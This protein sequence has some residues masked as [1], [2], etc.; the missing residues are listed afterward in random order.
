VAISPRSPRRPKISLIVPV[1]AFTVVVI[2]SVIIRR[3]FQAK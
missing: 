1:S 2:C 3:V